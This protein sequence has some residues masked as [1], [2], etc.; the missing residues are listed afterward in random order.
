MTAISRMYKKIEG[1]RIDMPLIPVQLVNTAQNIFNLTKLEHMLI[2]VEPQKATTFIQQC[3]KYGH[4]QDNCHCFP[5][6]V[7]Y[8]SSTSPTFTRS[9]GIQQRPAQIVETHIQPTSA[10][11]CS[12]YKPDQPSRPDLLNKPA[13]QN[14]S[15]LPRR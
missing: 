2:K 13:A 8:D 1:N 6:C 9:R 14:K 5:S 3:Q 10:D 4:H 12:L 15:R 7:K 11:L